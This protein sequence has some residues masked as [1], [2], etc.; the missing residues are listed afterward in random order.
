M[1]AIATGSDTTVPRKTTS[2]DLSLAVERIELGNHMIVLLAP[3][4]TAS[5]IAV[6]S[7]FRAGAIHEP[8]QKGG[9]AHLAEHL[10]AADAKLLEERGARDVNAFTTPS[11]MCFYATLPAEELPLALWAAADRIA[12]GADRASQPAFDRERRVIGEERN[13]VLVDVPYGRIDEAINGLIFAETHPLHGSVL[14]LSKELAQLTPADAR[15]FIERNITASNAVLTVVGRF[16]AATAKEWLD[17]TVARLPAAHASVAPK[18]PWTRPKASVLE[19]KEAQGRQPRV[20]VIWMLDEL[21]PDQRDALELGADLLSQNA[22][23]AFGTRV[24]ASLYAQGGQSYFRLDVL[25]PYNKPIESAQGEA[26]VFL[27]M[28]TGRDMPRDTYEATRLAR[29]RE[30]MFALD[31]LRTRA[32]LLAAMELGG[33]DPTKLARQLE[34]HWDF[35]RHDIQHIAWKSLVT[36][37]PRLIFHARPVRPLEAKIDYEDLDE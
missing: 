36:G 15:A 13:E 1:A 21:L 10:L 34:R 17:K 37:P 11:T 6:N 2:A 5:S 16:E 9:L 24:A 31:S 29:D 4:D 18:L 20:T 7:C 35:A 19:F 33:G 28:L 3:D 27:R 32:R 8:P 30:A 22:D 23:G 14:G 25:L 12:R 26:E